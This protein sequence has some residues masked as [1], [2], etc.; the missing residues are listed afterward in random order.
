[1]QILCVG[2][3]VASTAIFTISWDEN[4]GWTNH[5]LS[6]ACTLS[7]WLLFTGNVLIFCSIFVKLWRVDRVLRFDH[8]AVTIRYALKPLFLFLLAGYAI[9]LA[10]TIYDPWSWERHVVSDIPGECSIK[11]LEHQVFF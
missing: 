1:M 10:H 7:P 11:S 2:S 5:Q 6:I 8:S 4:A 9:L 3:F